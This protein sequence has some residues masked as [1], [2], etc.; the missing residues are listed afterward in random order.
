MPFDLT[1]QAWIPVRRL[2]GQDDLVSL[3]SALVQAHAIREVTTESPMQTA[4]LYRLLQAVALRAGLIPAKRQAWVRRYQH[5]EHFTEQA[6]H[7]YFDEWQDQKSCFDLVHPERP[8][9]QHLEPMTTRVKSPAYLFADEATGNNPT[10][11]DHGVDS[12]PQPISLARA[13][14]GV[15]GVQG[16]AL[17]GGN[18]KPFYYKNAPF[19]EGAIFWIRG[20]NLFEALMLNTPPAKEARMSEGGRPSWERAWELGQLPTPEQ[21]PEKGYVDYLTW[22]SRRVLLNTEEDESGEL[23]VVSLQIS[24]GDK[25]ED[26]ERDPLM[27]FQKSRQSG[28]YPLKLNR[29]RALWRDANV[30]MRVFSESE[31]GAPRTLQWTCRHLPQSRWTV[32]VFGLA[33]DRAKIE[34]WEH[35]RMPIYAR[36]MDSEP[37]Q[38]VLEKALDRTERQ[39]NNL[40]R[41][42]R[43]CA[44]YLLASS[45]YDTLSK[46]ERRDARELAQSIG[47]VSRY[48]AQ[49]EDAFLGWLKDLVEA[50]DPHYALA[51]WTKK[52]FGAAVQS[53]AATAGSTGESAKHLR[54]Q[55]KGR[56]ILRPAAAYANIL[57]QQTA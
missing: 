7:D 8:F 37:L 12:D 10:L 1:R 56:Q 55:A 47:A 15:V 36:I 23:Q 27:A 35:A 14:R 57:E 29:D 33:N 32:G 20:S 4:S 52:V 11:F 9:Y 3:R 31:G 6:V 39:S 19:I 30:F 40:Q 18:S 13:A 21:R 16:T 53:Y 45:G 51:S 42:T 43:E 50:T 48:W 22:P 25:H 24:Q 26:G 34:R 28:I 44:A 38:E 2:S 41:A 46:Q 17:A 49:L 5:G 54:A